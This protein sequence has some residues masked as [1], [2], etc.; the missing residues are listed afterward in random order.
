MIWAVVKDPGGTNATVRVVNELRALGKEVKLFSNGKAAEI[1]TERGMEHT[2]NP[3]AVSILEA[4]FS[5]GKRPELIL[6]SMC[7]Q[8]GLGKYLVP[9]AWHHDIATVAVQDF[10]GARLKTDYCDSQFWPDRIIVPDEVGRRLVLESWDDYGE[11][12]VC[13]SGWVAFDSLATFDCA[14]AGEKVRKR[15]G[16][17]KPWPIVGFFGHP[18]GNAETAHEVVRALNENADPVYFFPRWHP[19]ASTDDAADHER[20][21]TEVLAFSSGERIETNSISSKELTTDDIVGASKVVVS[22]FST[23]L[24][25]AAHLGKEVVSVLYPQYG[26]RRWHEI[27]K[28][29]G[30]PLTDLGCSA[31]V[32][33][34]DG[35][36]R[37]LRGAITDTLGL[38]D[39]QR[40]LLP[41][42]GRSA[43]RAAAYVLDMLRR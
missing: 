6:T 26:M 1:L 18:D 33:E 40:R 43:R 7:S 15:F 31:L 39:A 41:T 20:T 12:N 19:R 21:K 22:I 8:G 9:L 4:V 34:Y 17:V 24:V 37:T 25:Q 29:E 28:L 2:A 38:G 14:A 42:D 32:G 5:E 13:V 10:W 35:L 30:F 27:T 36:R 16:L 23:T 11:E 3:S